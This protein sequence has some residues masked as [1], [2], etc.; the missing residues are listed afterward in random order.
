MAKCF[1]SRWADG[2]PLGQ[3][4]VDTHMHTHTGSLPTNIS[5]LALT[6]FTKGLSHAKHIYMHNLRFTV[7]TIHFLHM[8]KPKGRD[9]KASDKHP[10]TSY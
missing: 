8:R 6:K 9:M 5:A 7:V 4:E 1:S 2:Q 10:A 3:E